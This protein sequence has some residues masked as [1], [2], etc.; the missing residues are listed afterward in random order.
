MASWIEMGTPRAACQVYSSTA[1]NA[2]AANKLMEA[3]AHIQNDVAPDDVGSKPSAWNSS[4]VS[5]SSVPGRTRATTT[6]AE[7]P[8]PGHDA[9]HHAECN[10]HTLGTVRLS[11]AA[12]PGSGGGVGGDSADPRAA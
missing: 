2:L 6:V 9:G 5:I 11:T 8:D 1:L 10:A 3:S 7:R 12:P 4:N